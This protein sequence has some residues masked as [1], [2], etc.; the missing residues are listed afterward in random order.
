MATKK[1]DFTGKNAV[2]KDGFGLDIRLKKPASPKGRGYMA[3]HWVALCIH[4]VHGVNVVG[5][6]LSRDS[7]RNWINSDDCNYYTLEF[8]DR[9]TD[10]V[11]V[12]SH[13]DVMTKRDE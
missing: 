9:V 13:L 8:S 6:F 2:L 5:P 3:C 4:P 7:A 10:C 1:S 11:W 12:V